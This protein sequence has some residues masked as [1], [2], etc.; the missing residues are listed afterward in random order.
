MR[1]LDISN[2][3]PETMTFQSSTLIH[4]ERLVQ[5][6]KKLRRDELLEEP[7][8]RYKYFARFNYRDASGYRWYT[9]ECRDASGNFLG[10]I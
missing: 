2:K 5:T 9:V 10:E 1:I 6:L 4:A 8:E 7:S 3:Q